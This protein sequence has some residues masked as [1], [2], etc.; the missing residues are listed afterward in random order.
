M[1]LGGARL[2]EEYPRASRLPKSWSGWAELMGSEKGGM[3]SDG[4]SLSHRMEDRPRKLWRHVP[5]DPPESLRVPKDGI[6]KELQGV[7]YPMAGESSR[8]RL[9]WALHGFC[10]ASGA[11]GAL[12]ALPPSR[13]RCMC[14]RPDREARSGSGSDSGSSLGLGFGMGSGKP[15]PLWPP[16]FFPFPLL[17]PS[18]LRAFLPLFPSPSSSFLFPGSEFHPLVD[19]HA[20][21]AG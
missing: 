13:R 7:R 5:Q 21:E 8:G 6:G 17:L 16:F 15:L 18:F 20:Q 19:G 4:P 3:P 11:C 9:R 1:G 2:P 12:W 14:G 10:S